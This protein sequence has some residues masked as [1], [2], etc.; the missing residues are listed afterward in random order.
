MFL[1]FEMLNYQPFTL[2]KAYPA[3]LSV[4]VSPRAS[5]VFV[6]STSFVS[7]LTWAKMKSS[8]PI[9]PP[10]NFCISTLWELSV[11][12]RILTQEQGYKSFYDVC[13]ALWTVL[14][15]FTL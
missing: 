6:T 9:W 4:M 7:P 11:Q 15:E 12:N 3:P 8:S 14:S 1:Y 5:S 13:T 2:M 10:N